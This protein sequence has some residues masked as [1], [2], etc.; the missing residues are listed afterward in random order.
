LEISYINIKIKKHRVNC[1]INDLKELITNY[2]LSL[3]L[4]KENKF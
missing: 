1:K 2:I 3:F 4:K